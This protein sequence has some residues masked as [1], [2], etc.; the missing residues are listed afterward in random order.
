MINF[1]KVVTKAKKLPPTEVVDKARELAD[2]LSYFDE[3]LAIVDEESIDFC[4]YG[5]G[6][7]LT[8]FADKDG[9]HWIKGEKAPHG[10]VVF[11]QGDNPTDKDL[12]Q[13]K[14]WLQEIDPSS[15]G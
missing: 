9:I 10:T 3:C 1:D 6:K 12:E 14:K 11:V 2:R 15:T 13:L 4:F 5:T 8:V 7:V